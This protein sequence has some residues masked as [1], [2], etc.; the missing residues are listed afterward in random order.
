VRPETISRR[1]DIR[2]RAEKSVSR[3]VA[4]ILTGVHRLIQE[5]MPRAEPE[6]SE[7]VYGFTRVNSILIPAVKR[8]NL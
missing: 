6:P 3:F 7:P 8:N 5:E 4:P 1:L 2:R